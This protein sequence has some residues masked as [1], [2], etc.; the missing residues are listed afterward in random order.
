MDS[1]ITKSQ[2]TAVAKVENASHYETQKSVSIL[3]CRITAR[4]QRRLLFL[5]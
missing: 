2:M 1:A 3:P 4:S 5:R